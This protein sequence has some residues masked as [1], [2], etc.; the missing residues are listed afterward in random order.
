M[1]LSNVILFILALDAV[2]LSV[3]VLVLDV[4]LLMLWHVIRQPRQL[5]LFEGVK[6]WQAMNTTEASRLMTP[7]RRL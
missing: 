7:R 3:L 2:A 6:A 4:L 1:A 5:L